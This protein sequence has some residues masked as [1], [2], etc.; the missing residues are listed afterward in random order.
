MSNPSS[1]D[2]TT[3][4]SNTG[5]AGMFATAAGG[6]GKAISAISTGESQQQMFDY[7]AGIANL[8]AQIASQ[9]SNYATQI[10]ELQAADAG[11]SG[12]QKMGQIKAAQGASG[13]DVNTGSAVDV[14]NSQ[15]LV[16]GQNIAAIRSNAAKTAYDYRVQGVGFGAEAQLDTFAGKNASEAGFINAGSSIIG[17]ASSVSSEWLQAQ[18]LAAPTGTSNSNQLFGG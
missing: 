4:N 13:L 18:K 11:I 3:T 10:G 8:N 16:T 12:A 7:Q 1:G 6:I 5:T 14:R 17:T 9:N 2:T 15:A